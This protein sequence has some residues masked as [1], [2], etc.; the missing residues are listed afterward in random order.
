MAAPPTFS[1]DDLK[2]RMQKSIA[3]LRDELA[4][5]AHRAAPARACSSR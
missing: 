2:T 4:G 3:S 5:P 1:L